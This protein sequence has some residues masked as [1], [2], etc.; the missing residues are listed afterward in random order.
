M[1]R[2]DAEK[3][4]PTE[5]LFFVPVFE[6]LKMNREKEAEKP[7]G[8]FFNKSEIRIGSKMNMPDSL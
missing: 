6:D 2:T 4:N 7:K 8:L 1:P 3:T 5:V